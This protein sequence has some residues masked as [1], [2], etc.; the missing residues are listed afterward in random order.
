MIKCE[1]NLELVDLLC[2]FRSDPSNAGYVF[3]LLSYDDE[4]L[5]EAI[6]YI[7]AEEL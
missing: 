4:E 1:P 5:N 3:L 6:N 7:K 2:R